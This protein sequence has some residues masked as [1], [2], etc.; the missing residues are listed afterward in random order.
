MKKTA[1]KLSLN[2]EVVR[3]LDRTMDLAAARGGDATIRTMKGTGPGA[4]TPTIWDGS[5]G[6]PT[7]G[8]LC[9]SGDT[10]TMLC[11]IA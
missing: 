1:K 7:H 10:L 8:D 9:G 5:C 11:H 6:C 4:C 2:R 3:S